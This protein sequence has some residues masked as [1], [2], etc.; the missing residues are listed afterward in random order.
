MRTKFS[1]KQMILGVLVSAASM[2]QV[3]AADA[4]QSL[5]IK[6]HRFEPAEIKV[7]ANQRIKLNVSNQDATPEEFESHSLSREKRI[8]AGTNAVIY[9]GPLKPGRYDFFGEFNP[10]TATGAVVA[11]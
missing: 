8:P 3:H 11:N 1:V 4:E 2:V 7:A 5:V 10:E 9:I 6:D